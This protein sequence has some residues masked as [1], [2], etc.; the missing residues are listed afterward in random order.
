MDFD[1]MF[2][3]LSIVGSGMT[4]QRRRMDVIAE[5]I[6]HAEDTNRGDGQPYHRKEV[7]FETV[8]DDAQRGMVQVSGVAEDNRTPL[9]SAYRPGDPMADSNG[10]VRMPNVTPVYEM[11][12]MLEA[13]R[14]YEANMQAARQFRSMIEQSLQLGR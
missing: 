3:A 6:A 11:V 4:A 5:N 1:H 10:N 12:D 8:L 13:S 7:V 9:P 2:G 14:A